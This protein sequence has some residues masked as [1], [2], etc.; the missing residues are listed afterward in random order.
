MDALDGDFLGMYDY[1]RRHKN[2]QHQQM[3]THYRETI[4][5]VL[6]TFDNNQHSRQFY[7]D[8]AWEGLRYDE[9]TGDNAIH[10]YTTLPQD[11]KDR[12]DNVIEGYIEVNENENCQ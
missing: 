4:A 11:E 8:L 9:S 2:W 7:M 1:Y 3:A 12:I 5:D 10:T 6:Q